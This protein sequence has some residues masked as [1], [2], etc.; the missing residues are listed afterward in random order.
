M[1]CGEGV[2]M[3]N[4][5]KFFMHISCLRFPNVCFIGISGEMKG[6]GKGRENLAFWVTFWGSGGGW[7]W[8]L[9]N[10]TASSEFI[11]FSTRFEESSFNVIGLTQFWFQVNRKLIWPNFDF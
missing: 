11:R 5:M 8:I 7:K 2:V 9:I 1:E 4:K 6:I 3:N 10:F